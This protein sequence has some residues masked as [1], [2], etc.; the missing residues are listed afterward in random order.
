[1]E[2]DWKKVFLTG[3]EYQAEM[4]REI[5]ENNGINA[6]VLNQQDGAFLNITGEIEVYVHE[7]NEAKANEI[8]KE[9][10]H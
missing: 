4:A 10:K 2:K 9:L 1:M 5:L 8:L 6:V 7:D 3:Q